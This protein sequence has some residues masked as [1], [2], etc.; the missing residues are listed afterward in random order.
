MA[1][2]AAQP[3]L[4]GLQ[5][6]HGDRDIRKVEKSLTSILPA[7]STYEFH[8]TS[9]GRFR[10][11]TLS[12]ARISGARGL[13]GDSRPGDD[14]S[15]DSGHLAPAA[16]RS[17]EPAGVARSGGK[18]AGR[19]RRRPPGGAYRRRPR[20]L[21]RGA[22]A[23]GLSPLAPL[24]P[25][26]PVY[27]DPGVAFDWTVLGIGLAVLLV[28]LGSAALALA[29][30]GAPHRVRRTELVAR[31]VRSMV[32]VGRGGGDV[33]GRSPRSAIR[34]RPGPGAHCGT[35]ALQR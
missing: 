21:A 6:A 25:V 8:V 20:V 12:Q 10:G 24:G 27:P 5:L 30:R 29:V 1:P 33:H 14:G 4:Y 15:R 11:R 7:G 9:Q 13:R 26:R 23:V 3:V 18:S 34:R 32:R 17:G 19:G 28:G 2:A 22:V 35:R 16:S 31:R